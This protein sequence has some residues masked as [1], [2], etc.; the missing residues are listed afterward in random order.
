M[1]PGKGGAPPPAVSRKGEALRA[2]VGDPG[3]R[4]TRHRTPTAFLRWEANCIPGHAVLQHSRGPPLPPAC[5]Q[6]VLSMPM[7]RT[8]G[9]RSSAVTCFCHCTD[10]L[11]PLCH[12]PW[13]QQMNNSWDC[14]YSSLMECAG[15]ILNLW[16]PFPF[17]TAGFV[18]RAKPMG[19]TE[20]Q[21]PA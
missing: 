18:Y 7:A 6:S 20:D 14:F 15:S 8:S 3:R 9:P 10:M 5:A 13:V 12:F 4:R 17:Q 21:G 16:A 1:E 19:Q 11:L 2:R